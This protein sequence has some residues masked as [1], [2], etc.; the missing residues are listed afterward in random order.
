[1]ENKYVGMDRKMLRDI[2]LRLLGE[3]ADARKESKRSRAR[4]ND[5]RS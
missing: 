3:V 1:M 5:A 4:W 2:E